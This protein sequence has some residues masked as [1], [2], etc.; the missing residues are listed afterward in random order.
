MM[1]QN[2][3]SNN[4]LFDLVFEEEAAQEGCIDECK[5]FLSDKSGLKLFNM[6]ICSIH[7]KYDKMEVLFNALNSDFDIIVLTE[8]HLKGITLF[9]QYNF[10]G[11]KVHGTQ[12]NKRKTDG[13]LIYVKATI[14]TTIHEIQIDD[15][16]C[17]CLKFR[18]D[19]KQYTCLALYR[20]P[21]GNADRFIDQ[22]ERILEGESNLPDIKILTGDINIDIRKTRDLLTEKYLNLLAVNGYLSQHNIITRLGTVNPGT[23]IDHMFVGTKSHTE[24]STFVLKTNIS[25]HFAV[26]LKIKLDNPKSKNYDTH[27]SITTINTDGII[28]SLEKQTWEQVYTSRNA[29]DAAETFVSTLKQIIDTNK[30]T[31]IKKAPKKLKTWI[32]EGILKAIKKRDKLNL[33]QKAQPFNTNLIQYYKKYRNKLNT[34]IETAKS[35]HFKKQIDDAKGDKKKIWN[36][37]NEVTQYKKKKEN[38]IKEIHTDQ[39]E[40]ILAHKDTKKAANYFNNYFANVATQTN[41]H[42]VNPQINLPPP[43]IFNHTELKLEEINEKEIDETISKMKG[44]TAPGH[45]EICTNTIKIIKPFITKPLCFI[46]N[47]CMNDGVFPQQFKKSIITPIYKQKGDSHQVNNYRPISLLSI[48]SKIFERCIKRRLVTYLEENKILS[49]LQF[50]FRSGKSTNDAILELTEEIYPQIGGGGKAAACFM[51]LSK[52][53][54]MV[55]HKALINT[56]ERIGI[57][58]KALNLFID[59][60]QDR[61]Q[62]VKLNGLKLQ[63]Q[64]INTNQKTITNENINNKDRENNTLTPYLSDILKNKPF[65][66]PQGT[67][68]SPIL[69]NIYVCG[70]YDLPLKG[71]II[72]F[73]DDTALVLKGTTWAEI[74]ENLK[75]DMQII[76][77]WLINKNLCLNID[78]TKIIPFCIDKRNLPQEKSLKIQNCVYCN[79]QCRCNTIEITNCIRYLG[80]QIDSHFRWEEHLTNLRNRLRRYIYPLLGLRKFLKMSL[81]KEVYYALIQSAIEYGICSYGRADPTLLKSLKTTQNMI[82]KII[83]KK[84]QRYPTQTL[85]AELEVLNIEK[86]FQ[87][88]VISF[89]HSNRDS[90]I[91][92]TDNHEYHLRHR[93]AITPLYKTKKGQKAIDYIGVK[94]YE[95]VPQ[96][97]KEIREIKTFKTTLKTW[98][99]TNDIEI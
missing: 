37:I 32:T 80:L 59:Y 62:Q 9:E 98:L 60:L 74:Y 82:L 18:K 27:Y 90:L 14:E 36:T 93:S 17:L 19:N 8:A 96:N 26:L 47:F 43:K 5:K 7:S 25:D 81:L 66:V 95:K 68:I 63:S 97:F 31:K 4:P 72:S 75:H 94:L 92:I 30:T 87:K 40:I 20:S 39:G 13:V 3:R 79:S 24:L 34:I 85:Y 52:A 49:H 11:Y 23:C 16:N 88:N 51:D 99:K 44:G 64:L 50:G 77:Q 61:T 1:S 33:L 86:L 57:K 83:Y 71:K 54:D 2:D 15:C 91:K 38:L 35:D 53:F 58:G 70:M 46:Y 89:V 10:E 41:N 84:K 69:Y 56:L 73:A 42:S 29:N 76:T 48:F 65:S 45:D 78:K 55:E 67:V 28:K 6:N 21:S 22:L 12:N